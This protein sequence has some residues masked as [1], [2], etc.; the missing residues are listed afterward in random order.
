MGSNAWTDAVDTTGMRSTVLLVGLMTALGLA[1]VAAGPSAQSLAARL[2]ATFLLTAVVQVVARGASRFLLGYPALRGGAQPPAYTRLAVVGA[3]TAS[4]GLWMVA[5]IPSEASWPHPAY[6]AL[7]VCAG[8]AL[9]RWCR[10]QRTQ[11]RLSG[12][13]RLGAAV[14]DSHGAGS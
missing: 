6:R 14:R 13:L 3:A 2:P 8:I 11:P 10:I 4:P 12:R 9:A 7:L 1:L 5:N